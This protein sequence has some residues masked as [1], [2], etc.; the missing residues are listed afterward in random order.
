MT[1]AFEPTPIN[2]EWK[3]WCVADSKTQQEI[4]DVVTAIRMND[5]CTAKLAKENDETVAR[6]STINQY[7]DE[8][9]HE[10]ELL[11]RMCRARPWCKNPDSPFPYP[12]KKATKEM[13]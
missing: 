7:M 11:D 2:Q 6:R 3:D 13:R 8:N 4:S 12:F 1:T 9:E 10:W 5:H